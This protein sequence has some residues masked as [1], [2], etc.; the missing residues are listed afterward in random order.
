MSWWALV[1]VG[2]AWIVVVVGTLAV[3]LVSADEAAANN[4]AADPDSVRVAVAALSGALFALPG[5]LMIFAGL[6]HRHP[7]SVSPSKSR[8]AQEG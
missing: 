5:V 4:L 1:L 2:I 8:G 7:Q 3:S 6:R